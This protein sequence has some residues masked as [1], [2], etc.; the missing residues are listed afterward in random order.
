MGAAVAFAVMLGIWNFGL[1]PAMNVPWLF[2]LLQD[3][4]QNSRYV[5]WFFR[6]LTTHTF[7][8]GSL[9]MGVHLSRPREPVILRIQ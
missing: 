5:E 2:R 7:L 6:S 3:C 8:F 4:F 9:F 1:L